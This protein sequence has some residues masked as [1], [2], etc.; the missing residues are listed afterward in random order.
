[1]AGEGRP[2]TGAR[3]ERS[4]D[5][6]R[7]SCRARDAGDRGDR[8]A[9]PERVRAAAP[10]CGRGG[11]VLPVA[12]GPADRVVREQDVPLITFTKGQRKDDVAKEHL[13]RFLAAGREE[14]VLFVGKAQEKA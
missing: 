10:A 8:S 14:G 3:D 11:G 9:V 7:G 5:G 4:T 12:P 1:M 6:G 13:A 2:T